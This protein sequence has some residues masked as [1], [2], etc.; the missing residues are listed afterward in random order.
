MDAKREH[1]IILTIRRGY[2]QK[3]KSARDKSIRTTLLE[4]YNKY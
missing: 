1:T 3:V 2:T 4:I